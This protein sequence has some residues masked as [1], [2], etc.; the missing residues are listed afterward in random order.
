VLMVDYYSR[1]HRKSAAV[2]EILITGKVPVS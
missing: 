1:F 2:L